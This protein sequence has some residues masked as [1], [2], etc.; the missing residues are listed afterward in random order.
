MTWFSDCVMNL[1]FLKLQNAIE[2]A[3]IYHKSNKE[4]IR[5]RQFGEH[6]ILQ[7]YGDPV[8]TNDVCLQYVDEK[9]N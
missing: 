7:Y 9:C 1:I 6:N 4:E 3:S 8:H 5:K 2:A